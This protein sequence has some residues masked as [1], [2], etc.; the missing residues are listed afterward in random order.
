MIELVEQDGGT[1]VA[2]ARGSAA[3]SSFDFISTT[4]GGEA[5]EESKETEEETAEAEGAPSPQPTSKANASRL[6][7]R[8]S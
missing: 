6:R 2:E 4:G 7:P 5:A 3:M 1:R 8:Q